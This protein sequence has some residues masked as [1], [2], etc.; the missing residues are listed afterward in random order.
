MKDQSQQ[1]PFKIF[2]HWFEQAK[3]NEKYDPTIMALA[4][5]TKTGKPSVRM[6]LFKAFDQRGLVFYTNFGSRKA[7]ELENN[8]FAA[9]CFYWP[10]IDKQVRIEGSVELIDVEEADA[11]FLTRSRESRIGAWASKQSQ[12][13]ADSKD[14]ER[15]IKKYEQQFLDKEVTRPEFWSGYRV[16]PDIF[17]FWERGEHRL[18]KRT[19]FARNKNKLWDV[20]YLYP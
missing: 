8:P 5:A 13:L 15:R 4:T 2:L 10:E 7:K 11:Y 12:P 6:V 19:C 20:Q 14:L 18:H 1:D 3:Q 16:I 17:E 9:L